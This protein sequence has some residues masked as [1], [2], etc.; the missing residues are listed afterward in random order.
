EQL[1][2]VDEGSAIDPAD[3]DAYI[4]AH[5]YDGTLEQIN[6]EYWIASFLAGP[7]AFANFRRSGYPD[8][9]PNPYPQ[10]EL[11]GEDFIRRLTYPTSGISV[12]PD[13]VGAAIARMGPDRLDTRIWWDV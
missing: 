1:S 7:E 2:I 11:E 10:D 6:D 5:P 9:P 4:N 8:L 13:N 3:V 12:K